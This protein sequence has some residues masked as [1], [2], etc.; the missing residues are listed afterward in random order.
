MLFEFFRPEFQIYYAKLL[1]FILSGIL[2]AIYSKWVFASIIE[3]GELTFLILS[4]NNS[5]LFLKS[6]EGVEV[7]SNR[8]YRVVGSTGEKEKPLCRLSC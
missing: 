5:F 6:E 7:G 4:L 8:G 1:D 3:G 2:F